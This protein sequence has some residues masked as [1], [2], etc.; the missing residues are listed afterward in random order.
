M[1]LDPSEYDLV[2]NVLTQTL[3]EERSLRIRAEEHAD[4][5]QE[6]LDD[7][8]RCLA[9]MKYGLVY[10]I[11]VAESQAYD[12]LISKS[13]DLSQASS[14][15]K[16]LRMDFNNLL[17]KHQT[18][19]VKHEEETSTV[20]VEEQRDQLKTLKA[21]VES[22]SSSARQSSL[23]LKRARAEAA[24]AATR[25]ESFLKQMSVLREKLVEAQSQCASTQ[26][27]LT[28]AR[29]RRQAAESAAAASKRRADAAVSR[30]E[31]V[32]QE[33]KSKALR[34]E[35]EATDLA[36]KWKST[37]KSLQVGLS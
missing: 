16:Q 7:C 4:A 14:A 28:I 13:V 20:K 21:E 1:A 30:A 6:E 17:Q 10:R 19:A 37:W 15:A 27:E 22:L 12:F 23:D 24:G 31:I 11:E 29:E 3:E 2:V 35:T 9:Q 5:L 18:E 36:A 33:S 34:S 32:V 8:S 26:A 25:A